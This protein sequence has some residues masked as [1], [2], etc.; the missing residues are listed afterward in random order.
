MRFVIAG[1]F[2]I[3]LLFGCASPPLNFEADFDSYPARTTVP[4]DEYVIARAF[5][6]EDGIGVFTIESGMHAA[7]GDKQ[8]KKDR[9]ELAVYVPYNHLIH[10]RFQVRLPSAT[11]IRPRF[12]ISQIKMESIPG[13]GGPSPSIAVYI[14]Q[15]GRVKCNDFDSFQKIKYIQLPNGS[16]DDGEWHAVDMWIRFSEKNGYCKVAV[17]GVTQIKEE[18]YRSLPPSPRRLETR[19]RIGPYRD[20][21]VVEKVRVEYDDWEITTEPTEK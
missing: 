5:E 7:T 14:N 8:G 21:S 20:A 16:I 13:S 19:A 4:H 17:D 10:Q 18:G 15:G 3:P 1:A 6:V 9:A 11:R 2:F 12:M